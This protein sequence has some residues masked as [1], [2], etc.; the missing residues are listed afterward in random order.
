MVLNMSR[1]KLKVKC[2]FQKKGRDHSFLNRLKRIRDHFFKI[3][4]VINYTPFNLLDSFHLI[5]MCG[6]CLEVT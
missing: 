5:K 1:E 6:R 3:E 4:E 2:F